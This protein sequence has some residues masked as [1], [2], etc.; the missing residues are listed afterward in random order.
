MTLTDSI[1]KEKTVATGRQNKK[2][3][4]GRDSTKPVESVISI[5]IQQR[6]KRLDLYDRESRIVRKVDL[7]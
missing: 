5:S 7:V 4:Y 1:Y 6:N 2:Y 3:I